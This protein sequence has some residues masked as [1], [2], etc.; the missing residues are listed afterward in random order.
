MILMDKK[1][2]LYEKIYTLDTQVAKMKDEYT[3]LTLEIMKLDD[4]VSPQYEVH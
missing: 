4:N 2:S 3:K 1:R